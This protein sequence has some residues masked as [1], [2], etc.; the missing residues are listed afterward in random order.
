MATEPTGDLEGA[1]ENHT[2]KFGLGHKFRILPLSTRR[3]VRP[4]RY[5]V[6][7]GRSSTEIYE[8]VRI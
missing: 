5:S 1:A 4:K 8:P 6:E 3:E 2:G 7:P